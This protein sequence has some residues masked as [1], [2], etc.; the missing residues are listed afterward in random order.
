MCL[1]P[2]IFVNHWL[3][4]S[5][6][7]LADSQYSQY[8]IQT[9]SDDTKALCDLTPCSSPL[10]C[11]LQLSSVF[12]NFASFLFNMQNRSC[13]R[14]FAVAAKND[15]ISS[16]LRCSLHSGICSKV[17]SSQ[18]PESFLITVS[19][20][21]PSIPLP[22]F[23]S[24]L[25]LYYLSEGTTLCAP[26]CMC[27]CSLPFSTLGNTLRRVRALSDSSISYEHPAL[28]LVPCRSWSA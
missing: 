22:F 27:V 18:S 26:V 17:T 9:P 23:H 21:H 24:A 19:K 6:I 12:P 1:D 13:F 3:I 25:P 8:K 2:T 20:Q 28:Y 14:G 15:L 11:L 5:F 4:H 16:V 10:T 7:H